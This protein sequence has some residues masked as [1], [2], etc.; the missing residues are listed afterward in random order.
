MARAFHFWVA[1]F[2]DVV[3]GGVVCGAVTPAGCDIMVAA[4]A[5]DAGTAVVTVGAGA[6][7]ASSSAIPQNWQKRSASSYLRLQRLQTFIQLPS[8]DSA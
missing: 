3:V 8:R 2:V 7:G 1:G 5:L 6:G 4:G